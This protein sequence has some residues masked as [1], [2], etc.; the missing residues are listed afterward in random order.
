MA[1]NTNNKAANEIQALK[2]EVRLLSIAYS[3]VLNAIAAAR[4]CNGRS[5]LERV[6]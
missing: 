1:S 3:L 6:A 2:F 4:L 5:Y